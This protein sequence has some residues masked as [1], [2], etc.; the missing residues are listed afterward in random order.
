M[1]SND[2]DGN[3]DP[4]TVVLGNTVSHGA[5]T[6]NADGSFTYTP[7]TGFLG[8]DS[9]TY[10][11]NDGSVDSN[12]AAVT[13]TVSQGK[14]TAITLT[15]NPLTLTPSTTGSVTVA[16]TR[17]AGPAGQVVT[18]LSSNS[19]VASMLPSVTIPAN[20]SSTTVT[21]TAGTTPGAATISAA[22]PG[23]TG[24]ST[25]VNVR[26]PTRRSHPLV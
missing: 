25:T 21:V 18:L 4:L 3:N 23:L 17:P 19:A 8:P 14:P 12:I 15:P 20:A 24:G 22:A 11:A 16:L 6:L 5:L 7:T 2:T 1:L 13:V 10:Q 9:F 26:C